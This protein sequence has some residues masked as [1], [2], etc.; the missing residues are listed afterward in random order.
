[1]NGS[2][3]FVTE[4][5]FDGCN[6]KISKKYCPNT[7]F[8]RPIITEMWPFEKSVDDVIYRGS[9]YYD[10]F[11]LVLINDAKGAFT[12]NVCITD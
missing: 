10:F 12:A 8:L 1:M 4:L 11:H 2:V 3:T 7:K 6:L 5:Y 9:V